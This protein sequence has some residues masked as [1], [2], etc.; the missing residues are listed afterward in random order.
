MLT[1]PIP[2]RPQPL[3]NDPLPT[4]I[5]TY[6][7]ASFSLRTRIHTDGL[8]SPIEV[9]ESYLEK[10]GRTIPQAAFEH[11]FFV[12]PDA[13]QARTPYFPD[14]ARTSRETYPN[15]GKGAK[16][17]WKGREVTLDDNA[18]AQQAWHKYTGRAIYRGS[19]YGVRHIWG[20]PWDPDAFTAGWNLCYMPF[21]VGMLTEEQ[22]PHPQL[23]QAVKQASW[24]LFFR[25]NP[26]CTPPDFV[27]DPGMDLDAVLRG[28][29]LLLLG[30]GTTNPSPSNPSP[31][32][33]AHEV[34]E[35][36]KEI[37]RKDEPE[38]VKHMQRDTSASRHGTRPIQH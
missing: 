31:S 15:K 9:L 30:A 2:A 5:P 18:Y 17:M 37:R 4:R 20:H 28:Q 33:P 8:A 35:R 24:D 32:S 22:H 14:R 3:S 23:Q 11:S 16:A 34:F 7:E 6:R 38:L 19:G 21:W 36:V 10:A 26:V 12:D 13:V 27:E 25:D 29:P 1:P